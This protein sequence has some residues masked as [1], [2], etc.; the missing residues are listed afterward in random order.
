MKICKKCGVEKNLSN[1]YPAKSC[2][3][4]LRVVCKSCVV[5]K[6][7]QYYRSK[8][9][10]DPEGLRIKQKVQSD[11][12]YA[13]PENKSR[14]AEVQ[15]KNRTLLR[16][17]VFSALSLQKVV[18]C[19]CCGE[20]ELKF[21][22]VDHVNNDGYLHRKKSLYHTVKNEGFPRDK[23]Q[24]LC[25]NCNMAKAFYGVCPHMLITKAVA[26]ITVCV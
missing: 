8:K 24:I 3:G 20:S 5:M 21:L 2:I 10:V 6:Q 11:K 1:F 7:M 19:A 9:E 18:R 23:Y 22:A 14:H 4:G 13:K 17:E 15:K 26:K 16:Q 12:W 25:H